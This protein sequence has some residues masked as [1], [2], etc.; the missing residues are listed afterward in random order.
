MKMVYI[1][2]PF[3]GDY[4]TNTKNALEYCKTATEMGVIPIAPH[5][6]FSRWCDDKV[7][8]ERERGLELGLELLAKCDEIWVMGKDISQG[9][10]D[11]IDRAF[12]LCVPMFHIQN[13]KD[14]H[15]YPISCDENSLLGAFDVKECN[16]RENLKDKIVVLHHKELADEFTNPL[17]QLWEV[18]HGPGVEVDYFH[19]DTVHLKHIIDGDR[20]A[21]G[22]SD[23]V[24][25]ATDEAIAN[26]FELYQI[27]ESFNEVELDGEDL[28]Q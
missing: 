16:T 3:K 18:T 28:C 12:E 25:I 13:Y 19:S 11:E 24:G 26:V 27:E 6:L 20:M 9:M 4:E 22:R 15:S 21:V 5:L 1:A 10:R 8:I 23:I 2:S 17:N 14:I 7:P